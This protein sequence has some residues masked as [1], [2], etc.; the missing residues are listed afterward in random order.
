M[1]ARG[2]AAL[3]CVLL[4]AGAWRVFGFV[5]HEPMWAYG[6]NYDQVRHTACSHVFPHRPGVDPGLYSPDAPLEQFS[7]QVGVE[8]PCVWTTEAV[9]IAGF[10][11]VLAWEEQ[12]GRDGIASVRGVGLIRTTLYIV[13][14]GAATLALWR[15]NHRAAAAGL[16]GAA[17]VVWADPAMLLWVNTFYAEYASV[18]ALLACVA[19]LLLA[20]IDAGTGRRVAW[21]GVLGMTA[22]ALALAFGKVQFAPMPLALALGF[23][24]AALALPSPLRGRAWWRIV[25]FALVALAALAVQWHLVTRTD[26]PSI[27][28][29]RQVGTFNFAFNGV[30]GSSRDPTVTAVRIGLP[31]NCGAYAGRTIFDF[32]QREQWERACPQVFALHRGRVLAKLAVGEP[33]TLARLAWRAV[34]ALDPWV[35]RELGHVANEA[36]G[37]V[38]RERASFR[39]VF[40]RARALSLGVVLAPLAYVLLALASRRLRTGTLAVSWLSAWLAN[41]VI[42]QQLV[43]TA[44]GDG[45]HDLSRQAFLV[46]AAA[47]GWLVALVAAALARAISPRGPTDVEENLRV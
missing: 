23:A 14:L 24:L 42:W 10:A 46:Y 25:P 29:W 2:L 1:R 13:V 34:T 15:R 26:D 11:R 22:A 21:H 31:A 19:L 43:L 30:L 7:R 47:L 16:A 4:L 39:R 12:S 18:I 17:A 36:Y 3:I 8:G 32:Q 40:E 28:L 6:N 27:A 20:W 37:D 35:Q 45:V 5:L 44:A 38:T 41:A 33:A 9:F